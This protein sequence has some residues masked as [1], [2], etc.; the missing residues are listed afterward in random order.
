MAVVVVCVHGVGCV[1]V[2]VVAMLTMAVSEAL[3]K[4]ERTKRHTHCN[5][6]PYVLVHRTTLATPTHPRAAVPSLTRF[7]HR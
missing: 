4:L 5:N 7:V 2:A 3:V 6:P 1:V